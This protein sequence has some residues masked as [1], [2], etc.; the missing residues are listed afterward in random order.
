MAFN[1]ISRLK[2]D[3]NQASKD[4]QSLITIHNSLKRDNPMASYP[5][6]EK[7]I[8]AFVDY[9]VQQANY[10][11]EYE[12]LQNSLNLLDEYMDDISKAFQRV[13]DDLSV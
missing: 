4:K 13:K 3:L 9:E 8:E 12:K 7:Q 6:I 1:Y 11:M 2:S 5:N 10:I